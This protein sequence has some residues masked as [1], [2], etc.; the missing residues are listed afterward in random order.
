MAVCADLI[1]MDGSGL[2]LPDRTAT[3]G[4]GTEPQEAAPFRS[5]GPRR[6]RCGVCGEQV[7]PT[8]V[9]CEYCGGD[10]W[11]RQGLADLIAA[12]DE[13]A[14]RPPASTAP[15]TAPSLHAGA[16][17]GSASPPPGSAWA[18]AAGAP[19]AWAAPDGHAN[20]NGNG[21]ANGNGNGN[22][23]ARAS[24]PLRP[25]SRSAP[26]GYT[27]IE[28]APDAAPG[29]AWGQ[30][31]PDQDV[32]KPPERTISVALA[33][34]ILAVAATFLAVS[35]FIVMKGDKKSSTPV[36]KPLPYPAS[37]DARVADIASFVEKQ[38]NLTFDHP[39]AVQFLTN[40]QFEQKIRSDGN[41]TS[42]DDW[43]QLA[44][45]VRID[46]LAG[47]DF[48]PATAIPDLEAGSVLGMYIPKDKVLI[49]KGD[50]MTPVVK[51]TVAHELTHALQDQ[52]FGLNRKFKT[53]TQD[54]AFRAIVEADAVWVQDAYEAT[55]PQAEQ[56]SADNADGA[57][58]ASASDLKAFPPALVDQQD[59][60]YALGPYFLEA[61]RGPKGQ[62]GV[63]DAFVNPPTSDAAIIRPELFLQKTAMLA[64]QTPRLNKGEHKLFTDNMGELG[65]LEML[66]AHGSFP[67][68]FHA[69][70]GYQDDVQVAYQ[71]NGTTCERISVVFSTPAGADDFLSAASAWT[72]AVPGTRV[73][74][75]PAGVDMDGCDPGSAA[76]ATPKYGVLTAL[77]V[78]AEIRS[79]LQ[80][81]VLQG[82]M[83]ASRAE[84]ISTAALS[85]ITQDQLAQ[86]E[87]SGLDPALAAKLAQAGRAAALQC[88]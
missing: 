81:A 82:T 47:P 67:T 56:A 34:L 43:A 49:V 44:A 29:F 19:P 15:L 84:C 31:D 26:P 77:V 80:P 69:L 59:F 14:A 10:P 74:R 35:V 25:D 68:A 45:L 37:W 32:P 73:T 1:G 16:P 22:G 13:A 24:A 53:S 78:R 71:K 21:H 48:N 42:S 88:P 36:A 86:L 9:V 30:P 55:L 7:R 57:N 72:N 8:A 28:P 40:D 20:G 46:G 79:T 66:A 54:G 4:E 18:N 63:D 51:V 70:D 52:H 33:V 83:N 65:L 5:S 41:D 3:D 39:V 61:I 11:S 87:G 85:H 75:T 17:T 23:H 64:A 6:I 38:R 76:P 60:P 62:L 2:A 50:Q 12:R 58:T 27:L